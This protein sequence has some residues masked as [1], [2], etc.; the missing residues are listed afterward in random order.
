MH[1]AFNLN[2]YGLTN[3]PTCAV[4]ISYMSI[5]NYSM[6]RPSFN[7]LSQWSHAHISLLLLGV[8]YA[9]VNV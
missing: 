1:L 7:L 3:A 4:G 8:N 9:L 5:L 6:Q 2:Q